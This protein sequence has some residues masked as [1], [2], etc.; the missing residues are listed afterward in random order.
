MIANAKEKFDPSSPAAIASRNDP[1]MVYVVAIDRSP[2]CNVHRD[3]LEGGTAFRDF[4]RE[5]C[6]PSNPVMSTTARQ[7]A[8]SH[9][10]EAHVYA[11]HRDDAA[12]KLTVAKLA[13]TGWRK[14]P[15]SIAR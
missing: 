13:D 11:V 12:F 15:Q 4:G 3:G 9:S 7:V 14:A 1:P 2:L 6:F 10:V 8:E 5:I